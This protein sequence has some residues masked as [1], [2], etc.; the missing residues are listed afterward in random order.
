[1]YG[2]RDPEQYGTITLDEINDLIEK[3][4][5]EEG[6]IVDNFQTNHEGE[7]VRQDSRGVL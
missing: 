3:T 4:A 1:M 6:I 2:K 5:K 7:M